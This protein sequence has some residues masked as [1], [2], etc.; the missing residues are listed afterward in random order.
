MDS[1]LN[2]PSTNELNDLIYLDDVGGGRVAGYVDRGATSYPEPHYWY[3]LVRLTPDEIAALQDVESTQDELDRL[4]ALERE[5]M[6]ERLGAAVAIQA[7]NNATA[8]SVYADRQR[9]IHADNL[10][11]TANAQHGTVNDD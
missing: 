2:E 10:A 3:R 1:G 8:A 5:V 11:Q 7:K 4:R 9:A 6:A